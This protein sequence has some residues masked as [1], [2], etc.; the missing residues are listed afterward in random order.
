MAD[1][2]TE[3]EY[4]VPSPTQAEVDDAMLGRASPNYKKAQ[5]KEEIKQEFNEPKPRPHKEENE[6]KALEA[7]KPAPG[8]RTRAVRAKEETE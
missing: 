2:K 3:E 7:S 5:I 6:E 8:Y 4:R 1:E